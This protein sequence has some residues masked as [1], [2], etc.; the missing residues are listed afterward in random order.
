MEIRSSSESSFTEASLWGAK[1]PK[2]D[3]FSR[4]TSARVVEE[5]RRG[6]RALDLE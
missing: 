3:E 2:I 1:M 4:E 5:K 6:L